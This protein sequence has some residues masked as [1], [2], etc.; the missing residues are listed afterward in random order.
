M[1]QIVLTPKTKCN[2]RESRA[3][4]WS[5]VCPLSHTKHQPIKVNVSLSLCASREATKVE[6]HQLL[7]GWSSEEVNIDVGQFLHHKMSIFFLREKETKKVVTAA[8]QQ[9]ASLWF[10]PALQFVMIVRP[11]YSARVFVAI[12]SWLTVTLP[13]VRFLPSDRLNC[14]L[15]CWVGEGGGRVELVG[16]GGQQ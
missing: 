5:V 15:Y 8:R 7:S 3:G 9:D 1:T 14:N 10:L 16:L 11:W 4:A 13:G 6:T 12:I 2:H